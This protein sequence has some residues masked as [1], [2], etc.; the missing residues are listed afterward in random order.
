MPCEAYYYNMMGQPF[1]ELGHARFDLALSVW[2]NRI[3][4]SKLERP[5]IL[6]PSTPPQ[7]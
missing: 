2:P 1:I 7:G 3:S 4:P 5:S 6:S